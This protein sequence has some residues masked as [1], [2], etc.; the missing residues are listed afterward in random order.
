MTYFRKIHKT[1]WHRLMEN[2]WGSHYSRIISLHWLMLRK[3]AR[4]W[5]LLMH[6]M[7]SHYRLRPTWQAFWKEQDWKW[8]IRFDW[9]YS[10]AWVCTAAWTSTNSKE[11]CKMSIHNYAF[12]DVLAAPQLLKCLRTTS[13]KTWRKAIILQCQGSDLEMDS[14]SNKQK[15]FMVTILNRF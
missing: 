10:R 15:L 1:V 3:R 7:V 12:L 9:R 6:R 8:T 13:F 11:Q 5:Q 4:V 2:V 14:L